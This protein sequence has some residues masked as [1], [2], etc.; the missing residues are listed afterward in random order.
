VSQPIDRS[1]DA[2]RPQPAG[3]GI[4]IATGVRATKSPVPRAKRLGQR[5]D[6]PASS[7]KYASQMRFYSDNVHFFHNLARSN[8]NQPRRAESN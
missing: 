6:Y 5:E 1:T 4:S 3:T 8:S 2:A 7:S